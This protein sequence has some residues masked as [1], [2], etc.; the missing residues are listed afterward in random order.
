M[1]D[2]WKSCVPRYA[3]Y[4]EF[5]EHRE[6]SRAARMM[7]DFTMLGILRG[8]H[9]DIPRPVSIEEKGPRVPMTRGIYDA[10]SRVAAWVYGS[11]QTVAK[12]MRAT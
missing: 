10:V 11:E 1:A 4:H 5:F 8:T 12:L 9:H 2:P 3:E 6:S 7:S